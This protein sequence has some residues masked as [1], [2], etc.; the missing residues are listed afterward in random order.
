MREI[1]AK[2]EQPLTGNRHAAFEGH[3]RRQA[4]RY[5]FTVVGYRPGP[6]TRADIE[7]RDEDRG[8][9]I[10]I[11]V[12][13]EYCEFELMKLLSMASVEVRGSSGPPP[14]D[15]NAWLA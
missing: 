5:G 1:E 14:A 12:W 8:Q 7:L 4:E 2:C 15:P 11:G 9:T 6:S 3:H 13:P 10:E